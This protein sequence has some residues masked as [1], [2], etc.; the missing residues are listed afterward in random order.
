M[1]YCPN[2][3]Q[4]VSYECHSALL[5]G[6]RAMLS[7]QPEPSHY[8]LLELVFAKKLFELVFAQRQRH[9]N[10]KSF[11]LTV[12]STNTFKFFKFHIHIQIYNWKQKNKTIFV[13]GF[14]ATSPACCSFG[15]SSSN[16]ENDSNFGIWGFQ[17]SDFGFSGALLIPAP[18]MALNIQ[19]RA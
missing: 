15:M 10:F 4:S 7:L 17:I 9:E 6:W 2:S 8:S 3:F 5:A 14:F 12:T 19:M 18:S 13:F 16:L 11:C 1:S